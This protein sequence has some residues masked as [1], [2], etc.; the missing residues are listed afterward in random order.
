MLPIRA[1]RA[2]QLYDTPEL[3]RQMKMEDEQREKVKSES[4]ANPATSSSSS[5]SATQATVQ[6]V[7]ADRIKSE[8]K[9]E[10]GPEKQQADHQEEHTKQ[11]GVFFELISS[12]S[13]QLSSSVSSSSSSLLSHELM[14]AV[15]ALAR[16]AFDRPLQQQTEQ[17]QQ[18]KEEQDQ[19]EL[20]YSVSAH[21]SSSLRASS[22]SQFS[23]D[24]M[25]AVKALVRKA[26]NEQQTDQPEEQPDPSSNLVIVN[27]DMDLWSSS[28]VSS[29][30]LPLILLP[31]EL[32][33][34]PQCG[35]RENTC[36]AHLATVVSLISSS[37]HRVVV[38]D[39]DKMM[40]LGL[41]AVADDNDQSEE[42]KMSSS[43][44]RVFLLNLGAYSSSSSSSSS[45]S[46]SSLTQSAT[47]S[48]VTNSPDSADEGADSHSPDIDDQTRH[49]QPLSVSDTTS[50]ALT[51]SSSSSPRSSGSETD[52]I[53]AVESVGPS[54][55]LSW[56]AMDWRMYLRP[57]SVCSRASGS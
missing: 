17:T 33:P 55:P 12:A 11:E 31:Q 2:K 25:D 8:T 28:S 40:E 39:D 53:H 18:Q 26:F 30:L 36:P 10:P 44:I 34:P 4:T 42:D 57:Q 37:V 23:H 22:G 38:T 51:L 20:K 45:F 29:L 48:S 46:S 19:S 6:T 54:C 13:A 47:I 35:L 15:K 1:L 49:H 3:L 14:D 41:H 56:E 5:S 32:W 16:K 21:L 43:S 52:R 50:T 24:M 27:K 7:D 9:I